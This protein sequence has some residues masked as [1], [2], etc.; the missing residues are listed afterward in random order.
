MFIV[1][2]VDVPLASLLARVASR[3]GRQIPPPSRPFSIV[4]DPLVAPLLIPAPIDDVM[5]GRH[6]VPLFTLP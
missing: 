4:L 1:P 5:L 6:L 2:E 3:N